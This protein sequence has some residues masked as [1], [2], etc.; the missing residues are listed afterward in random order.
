LTRSSQAGPSR[1]ERTNEAL[2]P[3]VEIVEY[4]PDWPAEFERIAKTLRGALG[5]GAQ[6]IDHIGS[7]SVPGLAAKDRIDVQIAVASLDEPARIIAAIS[8]VGYAHRPGITR[9]HVPPGA[10]DDASQWTKLFFREPPGQRATNIHIR[11]LGRANYRY[12]LLFR[13]YLRTHREA[14]L[15]YADAKRRLA[16][17]FPEDSATYADVKD[18]VCDIIMVAAEEWAIATNWK[19]S[20]VDN[21]PMACRFVVQHQ[22]LADVDAWM[23]TLLPA[24]AAFMTALLA[25]RWGIVVGASLALPASLFVGFPL[26]EFFYARLF[27]GAQ[28]D[29]METVTVYLVGITAF[30]SLLGAILGEVLTTARKIITTAR[31]IMRFGL[32]WRRS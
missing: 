6:R 3:T 7:T 10:I 28:W 16:Q 13:D 24:F 22:H 20:L 27:H 31:K 19:L 23:W 26:L 15:A 5:H 4:H 11:I 9:D 32:A 21:I 29:F 18:P 25:P 2:V 14:A 1:R 12:A 8:R 30:M 17:Q